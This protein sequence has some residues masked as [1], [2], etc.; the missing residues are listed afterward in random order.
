[1]VTLVIVAS[2]SLA[3]GFGAG[4]VKNAAKLAAVK[5]EI[6]AI[7]GNLT[8]DFAAVVVKIKKIL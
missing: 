6:T 2:V 5:S 4:R 7:E 8:T 3:V 1:M